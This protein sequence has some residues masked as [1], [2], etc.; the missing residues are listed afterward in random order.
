MNGI[1]SHVFLTRESGFE[2][3]Y[4]L[5]GLKVPKLRAKRGGREG[6]R[7]GGRKRGREGGREKWRKKWRETGE[8]CTQK[9]SE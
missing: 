8:K 7:E 6:G 1:D 5:C 9:G 3:V 2:C 4:T